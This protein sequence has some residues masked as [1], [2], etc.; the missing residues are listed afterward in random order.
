MVEERKARLEKDDSYQTAEV[1]R[2]DGRRK[3]SM[4]RE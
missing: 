4:T 3:K 1:G 2:G